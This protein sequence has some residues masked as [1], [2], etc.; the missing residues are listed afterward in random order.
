MADCRSHELGDAL[1]D[2]PQGLAGA[3]AVGGPGAQARVDLVLEPG[4]PHLEELVEA[5]GEDG[6]ELDPLEQRGA[7]VVGE[8]E[9]AGP[10]FEPRQL[11]V[12]EPLGAAC[13]H[14]V[15]PHQ[16]GRCR[17]RVAGRRPG[18]RGRGGAARRFGG[19]HRTSRVPPVRP[20]Q[21]SA[22]RVYR[23]SSDRAVRRGVG[24]SRSATKTRPTASAAPGPSRA[25][26]Q[27]RI[28]FGHRPEP[29]PMPGG[30][31]GPTVG[32]IRCPPSSV[33]SRPPRACGCAA[34]SPSGAPSSGSSSSASFIVVAMYVLA[35]VG[36]T[37][38]IPPNLGPFLAIVLALG[39]AAHVANRIYAPDA[40]AVILPIATLL[41][42]LGYVML[43]RIAQHWAQAQAGWTAIGVGAYILTLA[44]V[45]RSRDLDRYR[46]LLLLVA[47]VLMLSPLIPHL[48][49]D[50]NGARL[51]VGIGPLNGQPIELAKLAL[52]IFFASYFVEKR[53]LLSVPTLRVGNR[54]ML[55][56]RPLVPILIAW[57]LHHGRPRRRGRHRLRPAHLRAVHGHAVADVGAVELPRLAAS[58]C[59]AP[60]ACVADRLF[61]Q[62]QRAGSSE[63]LH[64][65]ATNQIMAGLYG[66]GTGGLLGTGLGFGQSRRCARGA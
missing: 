51:W 54:L 43:A 35:S 1:A 23:V 32:S 15:L 22:P 46:Y 36:T 37:S 49:Q 29:V 17:R 4:H 62:V 13:R 38:K 60:G 10:E 48:G 16:R 21:G 47:V 63:W 20:P 8:V 25:D 65:V 7:L 57:A 56:P 26:G 12:R 34:R 14:G 61:S 19:L 44:L 59:S 6:Q 58:S 27:P 9:Q 39:L 11:P 41:N 28:R 66:M 42:G 3:Q 5:L 45:R 52:C 50:K 18:G 30:A 2:G 33:A 55:D 53:E 31:G 40:S 64:P 24:W